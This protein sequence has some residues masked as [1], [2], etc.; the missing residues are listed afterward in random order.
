MTKPTP[1]TQRQVE[2]LFARFYTRDGD[3][4]G[5][6]LTLEELGQ[7]LSIT[8]AQVR[9]HERN[10][11]KKLF[12]MYLHNEKQV[13][14]ETRRIDELRCPACHCQLKVKLKTQS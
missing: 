12:A 7:K 1:L 11:F 8:S 2:V 5:T 4:R 14:F 3:S 13:D 9:S 10:A 6:P